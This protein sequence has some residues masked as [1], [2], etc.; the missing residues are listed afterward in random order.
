MSSNKTT[1]DAS[2][3][4]TTDG[5]PDSCPDCGGDVYYEPF[6]TGGTKNAFR[7]GRCSGYACLDCTWSELNG[8]TEASPDNTT[9]TDDYSERISSCKGCGEDVPDSDLRKGGCPECWEKVGEHRDREAGATGQTL[10]EAATDSGIIKHGDS[11][12]N[13][14]DRQCLGCDR[15]LDE[16]EQHSTYAGCQTCGNIRAIDST[17]ERLDQQASNS[18]RTLLDTLKSL[19]GQFR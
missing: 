11:D 17:L 3:D 8:S 15:P 10:S 7:N 19:I 12:T 18:E 2:T 13:T 6:L 16:V 5:N 9:D 14:D 4:S 1:S